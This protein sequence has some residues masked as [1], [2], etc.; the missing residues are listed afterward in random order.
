MPPPPTGLIFGRNENGPVSHSFLEKVP[1]IWL[2]IPFL[3]RELKVLGS[4]PQEE[5]HTVS[6]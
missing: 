2:N 3:T 6:V 5:S 4:V 1:E